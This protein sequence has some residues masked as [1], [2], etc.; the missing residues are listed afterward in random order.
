MTEQKTADQRL[1]D[2]AKW[3]AKVDKWRSSVDALIR[4]TL[5]VDEAEL[6]G[7]TDQLQLLE[8]RLTAAPDQIH[9]AVA[10]IVDIK[11]EL[12]SLDEQRELV[13]SNL[14]LD[15]YAEINGDG[16]PK[17][18]NEAQR[19]AALTA[20]LA[21]SEEYNNIKGNIAA[22]NLDKARAEAELERLE[23]AHKVDRRI[24]YGS[25]AR[26]ENLTARIQNNQKEN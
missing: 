12:Q 25:V 8:S 18:S 22:V 6:N 14:L 5:A 7:L 19:K 20:K 2:M 21:G 16:K 11:A 9:A 10:K 23:S 17:Y 13:E 24:Y 15:V 3:A 1:N 4:G 26:L